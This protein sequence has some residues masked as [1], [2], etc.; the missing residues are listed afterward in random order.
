VSKLPTQLRWSEFVSAL[1]R[2]KLKEL[3]SKRGSA[4]HF[5]RLSD[6]E[7]LTFHEPHG[8]GTIKQGT[9]SEYLR[10]LEITREQFE[11]ALYPQ[12]TLMESSE[13]RFRRSSDSDGTIISNCMRCFEVV[14]RSKLEEEILAAEAAHACA[15]GS[16]F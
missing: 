12:I 4:R 10:K 7:I 6:S 15:S 11:D 3:P 13:E 16:F 1:E 8:K 2:L 14:L 5:Q 9:L